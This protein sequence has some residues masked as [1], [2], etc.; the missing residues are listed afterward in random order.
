MPKDLDQARELAAKLG[1]IPRP[2]EP[3]ADLVARYQAHFERKGDSAAEAKTKAEFWAQLKQ[4]APAG[5]MVMDP[6]MNVDDHLMQW[7][8]ERAGLDP[9]SITNDARQSIYAV[10]ASTAGGPPLA[11]EPP[12][13]YYFPI[14]NGITVDRYSMNPGEDF[15]RQLLAGS[16]F[17]GPAPTMFGSGPLPV[18]TAS[19]I[20]AQQLRWVPWFYRHTAA[21]TES[22]ALVVSLIEQGLTGA[23]D[24]L[25]YQTIEGREPWQEYAGRIAQWVQAV[26]LDEQSSGIDEQIARLY[27]PGSDLPSGE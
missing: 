16:S 1:Y 4:S 11:K 18:I 6:D 7:R 8:M 9:S 22:R 12:P 20:D 13:S 14:T 27:G 23:I 26:P 5:S 21:L 19:G 15:Y 10:Q 25:A 24:P 3:A 2:S 17:D